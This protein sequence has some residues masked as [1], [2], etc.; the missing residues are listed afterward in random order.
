MPSWR[1]IAIDAGMGL[2]RA[3]GAHRLAE[4]YTRG[5]GAILMFHRVHHRLQ[6]GFEPNRGLE[7]SIDFFDALLKHLRQK[8]YRILSMDDALAELQGR[9]RRTRALCRAHL[10]RRLPRS[11]RAC[12]A[13]A[14][15]PSRAHDRLCDLRLRR[16]LGAH[17]VGGAGRVDSPFGSRRCRCARASL[18]RSMRRRRGKAAGVRGSLLAPARRLRGGAFARV[19]VALRAGWSGAPPADVEPVPRLAR[20]R[21]NSRDTSLSPSAPIR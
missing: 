17:V 4:P 13:R 5:L 19:A 15:A 14:G 9:R 16:W 12:F 11:H 6:R 18:R 10:R 8:G 7:I 2:F 20:A 1:E 21:R 3:S